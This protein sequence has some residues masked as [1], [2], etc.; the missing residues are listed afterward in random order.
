ML[1]AEPVQR[2]KLSL[3]LVLAAGLRLEPTKTLHL[4]ADDQRHRISGADYQPTVHTPNLDS[5]LDNRR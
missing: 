1:A 2:W 3:A 5:A 4:F